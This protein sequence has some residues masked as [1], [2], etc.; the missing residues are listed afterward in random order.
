LMKRYGMPQRSD[1]AANAAQPL[2]VNRR[3]CG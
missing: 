2:G 3:P 1:T